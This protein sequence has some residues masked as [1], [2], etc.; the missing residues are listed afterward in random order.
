MKKK[1]TDKPSN[2]AVPKDLKIEFRKTCINLELKPN[3]IVIDMLQRFIEKNK[4]RI[5][6]VTM[7][8]NG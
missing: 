8:A 4:K 6:H 1:Q 2:I 3:E 7:V 5:N